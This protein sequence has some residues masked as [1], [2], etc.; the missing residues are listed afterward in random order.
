M[1]ETKKEK[2]LKAAKYPHH[3]QGKPNKLKSWLLIKNS[4]G[5]NAVKWHIQTAERKKKPVN[6][7]SYTKENYLSKIN[8]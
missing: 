1:Q 6:Q 3:I 8:G 7:E 2:I 5:Q 4:G